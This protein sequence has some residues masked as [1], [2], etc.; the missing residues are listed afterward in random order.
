[1]S[2]F[3]SFSDLASIKGNTVAKPKSL[4]GNNTPYSVM[5]TGPFKEHKAKSGNFAMRF[6][7]KIIECLEGEAADE[8]AND[9]LL[10]KAMQRDYYIDFWMSPD[11][12]WR[13]TEF[14]KAMGV[15]SEQDLLSMAEDL[16]KMGEPFLLI[17]TKQ[18]NEKDPENPYFRLDNPAPLD[19][20]G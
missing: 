10:Q 18:D 6:P 1:M 13:F 19:T 14:A 11:A 9:E 8:I 3:G 7:L 5:I 20:L 15:D 17:G 16:V 4:P 12:R 2:D